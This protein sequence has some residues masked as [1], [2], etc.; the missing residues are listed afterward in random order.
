MTEPHMP[1]AFVSERNPGLYPADRL[2]GFNT[3]GAWV[4]G[5]LRV[6]DI[7]HGHVDLK[8][9]PDETTINTDVRA[10]FPA[11][12]SVQFHYDD[13]ELFARL[14]E[15]FE[16]ARAR[17]RCLDVL[18]HDDIE[19]AQMWLDDCLPSFTPAPSSA[20]DLSLFKCKFAEIDADDEGEVKQRTDDGAT[21]IGRPRSCRSAAKCRPAKPRQRAPA[22]S[23]EN[24]V[25]DRA[26]V[27]HNESTK[28]WTHVAPSGLRWRERRVTSGCLPGPTVVNRVGSLGLDATDSSTTRAGGGKAVFLRDVHNAP[29]KDPHLVPPT[30]L[31]TR[32]ARGVTDWST[33]PPA[34]AFSPDHQTAICDWKMAVDHRPGFDHAGLLWAF[35]LCY[36]RSRLRQ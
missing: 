24:A 13:P 15:L 29:Y 11:V 1:V 14:A 17:L 32:F 25:H 30:A 20:Y 33:A 19:D 28:P 12:L 18:M 3:S 34:P 21:A 2:Y 23:G 6:L 27:L 4:A 8:H 10:T 22:T 16:H 35:E 31:S 5:R 9:T 36:E 26:C 7:L